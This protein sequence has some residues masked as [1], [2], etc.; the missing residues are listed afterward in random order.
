MTEDMCCTSCFDD[1][2]I[3]SFIKELDIISDCCYCGSKQVYCGSLE[4]VGNFIREGVERAYEPVYA[5]TGSMYDSDTKSYTDDG[6]TVE[7]ILKWDLCIYSDN[8]K[9][10][11]LC[12]DLISSSGPSFREIQNGADDWLTEQNLVVKDSLYGYEV[13][14]QHSYWTEFKQ[15]CKHFNRFFDLGSR[16]SSR[17]KV[18]SSLDGIFASMDI[19]L[20][21]GTRIY[22]SRL[23]EL[24]D[25]KSLKDID[26]LKEIS[27]PPPTSAKNNRMSP[28]GISYSYLSSDIDTCL[29][30]VHLKSNEKALVGEFV[31]KTSL[32]I[33]DISN[34]PN[35]TVKSCFSPD[36]D[37]SQIWIGDF[38][39]CFIKEISAP[40]SKDEEALEYVA[41]QL[42]AEYIR[43]KG[44]HGIRYRSSLSK[45]GLNY[46]LFCSINRNVTHFYEEHHYGTHHQ[47]VPFTKWLNLISVQYINGSTSYSAIDKVDHDDSKAKY[48]ERENSEKQYY[49]RIQHLWSNGRTEFEDTDF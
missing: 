19:L 10:E 37:H 9:S 38:V 32:K 26:L 11:Q 21:K 47:I 1:I 48:H 20:P 18:L 27:P 24:P 6:D 46:V 15:S 12:S 14:M 39:D 43:K 22:R 35:Y 16:K 31:T 41:T 13:T 44:Y 7:A 5:G 29:A 33:L 42:L 3:Q 40:I 30:E 36:Y 4:D 45:S 8:D 49:K 25:G 34:A 2:E 28:A 17:A 23:F